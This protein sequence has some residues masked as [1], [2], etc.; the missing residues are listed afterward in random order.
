MIKKNKS[1]TWGLVA[2]LILRNRGL[3]M[4]AIVALTFFW[5]SQ[6]KYMKFTFT[7]ANLLPDNHPENILYKKFTDTFGEEGNVIVIAFQDSLFF[8]PEKREAWRTLNKKL[9]AF[10]E[11][12][13]V[14]STDNLQEL[15]KDQKNQKFLLQ[16]VPLAGASDAQA[17]QKFKAKL[18]LELP[19]YENLLFE[20]KSNT[21]RSV[22]Y[23]DPEIVNTALR[24]DFVIDAFIPLIKSFETTQK[25]I[26]VSLNALYTHT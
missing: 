26:F 1:S 6:W 12:N 7:E 18:F 10:S 3:L 25:R 20:A 13:L 9:E 16:E 19:F 14:L 11:I 15:V 8:T 22:I 17:L 21:V 24:K 2:R 5:A 4:A 23:M